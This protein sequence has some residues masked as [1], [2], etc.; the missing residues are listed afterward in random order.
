MRERRGQQLSVAIFAPGWTHETRPKTNHSQLDHPFVEGSF[1]EREYKFW[2]LLEKFLKF[3][4]QDIV[5]KEDQKPAKLLFSTTFNAG[6][7]LLHNLDSEDMDKV[8]KKS[9]RP[10]W[11]LDLASQELL[12]ILFTHTSKFTNDDQVN[13]EISRPFNIY[14][15]IDVQQNVNYPKISNDDSMKKSTPFITIDN[16]SS[17]MGNWIFC[18][19]VSTIPLFLTDMNVKHEN[20]LFNLGISSP[21][22]AYNEEE[23]VKFLSAELKP[24]LIIR[25]GGKKKNKDFQKTVKLTPYCK[26]KRCCLHRSDDDSDKEKIE[27]LIKDLDV[28]STDVQYL[29]NTELLKNQTRTKSIKIT[30]ILIEVPL[31]QKMI[32]LN[33]FSI[34]GE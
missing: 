26:G 32:N 18:N 1:S 10:C 3:R 23:N 30:A 2:T 22:Q 13:S 31:G 7:G 28:K 34:H 25:Y 15:S 16:R 27:E 33:R 21:L 24:C 8:P 12:P 14:S 19:R 11:F 4:S 9:K 17:E 6:S 29:F 20:L 5:E